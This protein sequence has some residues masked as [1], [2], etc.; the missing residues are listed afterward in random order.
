M[1]LQINNQ[2]SV[3]KL[4]DQLNRD[5]TRVNILMSLIKPLPTN[6]LCLVFKTALEAK[7]T[8]EA[9]QVFH[10]CL[11]YSLDWNKLV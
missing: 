11:N 1:Y 3:F 6:Y 10:R 9:T 5:L 7:L 2:S 4:I 8:S